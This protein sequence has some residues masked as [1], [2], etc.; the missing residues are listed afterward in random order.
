VHLKALTDS[1][2]CATRQSQADD[3]SAYLSS[4]NTTP[5][6]LLG[7]LND[8]VKAGV[9]ICTTANIDTL[10][11]IETNSNVKFLT[12]SPTLDTTRFTN[13]SLIARR[14]TILVVNSSF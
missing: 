11:A 4:T 9:G 6:L 5:T 2:A 14:S 1:T 7:D 10:N 13:I 12:Q 8:E 3:L